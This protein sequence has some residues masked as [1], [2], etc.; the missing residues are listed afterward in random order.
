MTIDQAIGEC[1]E[2]IEDLA[3]AHVAACRP[4]QAELREIAKA[5][6]SFAREVRRAELRAEIVRR[7]AALDQAVA[8][9]R[10]TLRTFRATHLSL[11]EQ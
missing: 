1:E 9:E 7:N 2:R 11:Q 6:P 3:A 4:I 10:D 8:A 5:I